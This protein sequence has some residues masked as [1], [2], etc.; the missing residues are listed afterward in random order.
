MLQ[1][2]KVQKKTGEFTSLDHSSDG[3]LR[4]RDTAAGD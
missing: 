1:K 3:R 4:S 2:P